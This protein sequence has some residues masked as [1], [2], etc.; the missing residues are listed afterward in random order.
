MR[1]KSS[2]LWAKLYLMYSKCFC[3]GIFPFPPS[4]SPHKSLDRN[5]TYK[6]NGKDA[7]LI[8]LNEGPETSISIHYAQIL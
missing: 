3:C 6:I 1:M 4:L 8:E 2:I 5:I 7:V